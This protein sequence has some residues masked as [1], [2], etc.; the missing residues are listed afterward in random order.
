MAQQSIMLK[1]I[2]KIWKKS[3][4][5]CYSQ[6]K[7]ELSYYQWHEKN[8]KKFVAYATTPEN[9]SQINFT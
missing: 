6:R 1:I 8:Y 5:D 9:L 4:A 7:N 2:P 3:Q